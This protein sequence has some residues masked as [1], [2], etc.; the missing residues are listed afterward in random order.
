MVQ[1]GGIEYN[2][3]WEFKNKFYTLPDT[4]LTDWECTGE[5]L[6]DGNDL[7][8]EVKWVDPEPWRTE[9]FWILNEARK[10]VRMLINR[11]DVHSI[12][13]IRFNRDTDGVL[14]VNDIIEFE[15]HN[16]RNKKYSYGTGIDKYI[17]E[18]CAK[19]A[20]FSFEIV[21]YEDKNS[22]W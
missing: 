3:V 5:E 11:E 1:K 4:I 8:V 19:P 14:S 15:V 7:Y 17:K 20:L 12:R 18:W 16:S 13:L 2:G 10:T 6:L 22:H 21:T 9:Q